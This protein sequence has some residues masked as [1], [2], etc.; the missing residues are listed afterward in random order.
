MRDAAAAIVADHGEAVEAQGRHQLDLVLG[1]GALAVV[2]VALAAGRLVRVAIAAQIGR[3]DGEAL[4]ED[5]GNL[6]PGGMGLR[7][8]VQQEQR[9]AAAANGTAQAHG[10][11]SGC[12]A[13]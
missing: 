11:R 3:D 8:A 9:R 12:R 13:A 5:G 4:G 7:V 6:V 10:R 2:D 1:H